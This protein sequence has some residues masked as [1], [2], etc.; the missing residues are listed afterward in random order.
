MS[1]FAETLSHSNLTSILWGP[2]C[3]DLCLYPRLGCTVSLS[4]GCSQRYPIWLASLGLV[5]PQC[6]F[7]SWWLLWLL[8]A[9]FLSGSLVPLSLLTVLLKCPPPGEA[10]QPL[11]A[12][13]T[14]FP[15]SSHPNC[16]HLSV[17]WPICLPHSTPRQWDGAGLCLVSWL[18]AS[19]VPGA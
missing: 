1:L 10:F 3:G 16:F 6:C 15:V 12:C 8:R 7:S 9:H 11:L 19:S 2:S 17:C 14:S 4:Q 5:P 18:C 13:D